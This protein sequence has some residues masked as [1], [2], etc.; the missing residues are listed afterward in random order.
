MT[1]VVAIRASFAWGGAA[2]DW[3]DACPEAVRARAERIDRFGQLALGAVGGV[4]GTPFEAAPRRDVGIVVGTAF[5]CIAT[6]AAYQHR[7]AAH[8]AGGASPRLFA[9]TVS[10][11]AAG[12]V[13]IAY[14]IGGPTLTVTAGLVSG[15]A[16]LDVARD[17]LLLGGVPGMVV[18]ALDALNL[19]MSIE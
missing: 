10:N 7:L 16:A 1:E 9:A 18:I 19:A 5:G 12:E 4:L 6:N 14:G 8:G 2:G 17:E 13:G 11:A 3:P 15:L